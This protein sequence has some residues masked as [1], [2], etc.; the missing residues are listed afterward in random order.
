MEP[1]VL[2]EMVERQE[3]E[4]PET[5][6]PGAPAATGET[7]TTGTTGE[8]GTAGTAGET[9]TAGTAG[10]TGTAAAAGTAR[11]AEGEDRCCCRKQ[12]V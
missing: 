7:A 5:S 9:S 8:T 11:A 4:V 12:L 6:G 2:A 3:L 10:E 1:M